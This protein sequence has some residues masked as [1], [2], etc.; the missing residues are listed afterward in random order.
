MSERSV[1]P[2]FTLG[3]TH[4]YRFQDDQDPVQRNLRLCEPQLLAGL[5][6]T[7]CMTS[8][9]LRSGTSVK[10][11]RYLIIKN[12]GFPQLMFLTNFFGG[13]HRL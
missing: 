1:P 6:I 9:A 12:F 5:I 11:L 2:R 3:I 4:E 7:D 10:S 13:I 8:S